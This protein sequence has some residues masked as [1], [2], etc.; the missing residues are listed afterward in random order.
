MIP[1]EHTSGSGSDWE[2][3]GKECNS[4]LRYLWTKRWMHA[5]QK[6]PEL[7]PSTGASSS[8]RMG[9]QRVP[10]TKWHPV[11][12]YDARPDRF[13]EFCHEER[14]GRRGE[15]HAGCSISTVVCFAVPVYE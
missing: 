14:C 15:A 3:W 5:V 11:V 6:D 8:E 2:R 1:C 10:R 4:L 13:E 9:K 12:D 7:R